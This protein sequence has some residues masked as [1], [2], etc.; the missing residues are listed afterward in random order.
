[1]ATFMRRLRRWISLLK[2]SKGECSFMYRYS[3]R[4]SC[5]QFDSLPLTSLT[6]PP[7]RKEGRSA[8]RC[9]AS[10]PSSLPTCGRPSTSGSHVLGAPARIPRRS[11]LFTSAIQV[12]ASACRPPSSHPPFSQNP[13]SFGSVDPCIPQSI[14]RSQ[15][16]DTTASKRS[17]SSRCCA[18]TGGGTGTS[19]RHGSR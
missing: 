15:K 8:F 6:I 14:S 18:R 1:M 3:L 4:E 10:R 19:S 11:R 7:T 9:A 12:R 16:P 17:R 13:S 2:H 5:S